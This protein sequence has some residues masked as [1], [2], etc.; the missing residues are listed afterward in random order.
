MMQRKI[1]L[2]R[3]LAGLVACGGFFMSAH[4]TRVDDEKTA[5]KKEPWKPEDFIYG[6]TAGAFRNLPGGKR[7]GCGKNTRDK[8]KQ[9]AVRHPVLSSLNASPARPLTA[10]AHP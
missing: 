4:A 10:G 1:V 8:K 7:G 2:A 3:L 5:V 9:I 6:E